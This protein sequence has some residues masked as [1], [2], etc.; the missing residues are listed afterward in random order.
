VNHL[1]KDLSII[2]LS[3]AAALVIWKTG[4]I[5]DLMFAV[6]GA[7]I[8]GSLIAGSLF[9]SV[10][11]ISLSVVA[12][13]EISEL[14]PPWQVAIIGGFGALS[15]DLVLLYLFKDHV[16]GDVRKIMKGSKYEKLKAV[17]RMKIFRWLTPLVGAL[18][19]ASPLPNELGL[20]ILGIA[21][22]RTAVFIPISFTM[23]ALGIFLIG[24]AANVL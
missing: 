9:P 23:N 22:T 5:R 1:Q 3:V 14:V 11:T 24:T 8:W 17:F 15:S 18:I 12:I 20:S 6:R 10:L 4:L 21:Q 7:E 16:A 19:I 13:G 2:L